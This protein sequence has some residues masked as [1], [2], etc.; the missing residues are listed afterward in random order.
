[1]TFRDQQSW[2]DA[3][4]REKHDGKFLSSNAFAD[5]LP[6]V[7][8]KELFK[9]STKAAFPFIISESRTIDVSWDLTRKC[10]L[11]FWTA[12][13]LWTAILCFVLALSDT[14]PDMADVREKY[15]C[16]AKLWPSLVPI[17]TQPWKNW[18]NSGK[19]SLF[20][21]AFSMSAIRVGWSS[22]RRAFEA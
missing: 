9:M 6:K 20:S 14:S 19:P 15:H 4:Q 5:T 18:E 7:S 12:I 2:F 8:A 1:M 13:Q 16:L 17:L 10:L 11:G 22:V 21:L 3:S